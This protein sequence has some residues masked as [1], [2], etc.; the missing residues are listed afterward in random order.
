[1]NPENERINYYE[2]NLVEMGPAVAGQLGLPRDQFSLKLI[3]GNHVI[4][5]EYMSIVH[6]YDPTLLLGEF[7][8]EQVDTILRGKRQPLPS[9]RKFLGIDELY[10]GMRDLGTRMPDL[11]TGTSTREIVRH[12]NLLKY[13]VED[14]GIAVATTDVP[15]DWLYEQ[16]PELPWQLTEIGPYA[17]AAGLAGVSLAA[18]LAEVRDALVLKKKMGRRTLMRAVVV[19]GAAASTAGGVNWLLDE[20]GE[21]HAKAGER[22][23]PGELLTDAQEQFEEIQEAAGITDDKPAGYTKTKLPFR[24]NIMAINGAAEVAHWLRR[25]GSSGEVALMG[26]GDGHGRVEEA[27]ADIAGTQEKVRSDAGNLLD[28]VTEELIRQQEGKAQQ[29]YLKLPWKMENAVINNL[30]E[31]SQLFEQSYTIGTGGSK[32]AGNGIVDI[33][34]V[35]NAFCIFVSELMGK[36]SELEAYGNVPVAGILDDLAEGIYVREFI[37]SRHVSSRNGQVGNTTGNRRKSIEGSSLLLSPFL[38]TVA[39][40][41]RRGRLNYPEEISQ[42]F[43]YIQNLAMVC[44]NGRYVPL[45]AGFSVDNAQTVGMSSLMKVPNLGE[46]PV[47]NLVFEPSGGSEFRRL[48]E[49]EKVFVAYLRD[50]ANEGK[51]DPDGLGPDESPYVKYQMVPGSFLHNFAAERVLTAQDSQIEGIFPLQAVIVT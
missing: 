50:P 19:A 28:S 10:T 23:Y 30:V 46:V 41:D 36:I 34:P 3:P 2:R 11:T 51:P 43:S 25:N 24:T 47:G 32:P 26:Y 18:F 49:S 48:A 15:V 29:C 16:Y 39:S 40:Y 6:T 20:I 44:F 1:M 4:T 27:L 9:R 38:K 22:S 13:L 37:R 8:Y 12:N 42:N 7:N 5:P 17:V 14:R 31:M 45:D 33:P 35:D 21:R